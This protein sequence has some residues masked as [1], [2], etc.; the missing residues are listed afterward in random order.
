MSDPTAPPPG[1]EQYPPSGGYPPQQ[2]PPSQPP[3]GG[4][5]YPPQPPGG[6]Q[7]PP[8][9][10]GG[11]PPPQPGG[12]PPQ[13]PPAYQQ[14]YGQPGYGPP[15]T[16]PSPYVTLMNGQ[17]VK[18]ADF[19]QRAIGRVID[20]VIVWVVLVIINLILGAIVFG[21]AELVFNEETQ[22]FETSGGANFLVAWFLL[23]L[24]IALVVTILYEVMF[25]ATRGQTPGK[26]IIGTKVVDQA[27]GELIGWGP[28]FMRWLLP[29]VGYLFCYLGAILVYLSP[30]FDKSGRFQGWH[31]KMG[32]DLVISLK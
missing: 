31:D 26:M 11:Y 9:P 14:P 16:G 7:Y 28:S 3:P 10:P 22:Q 30:L 1:G 18:V 25:V 27:T 2:P 17:S 15:A 21:D 24:A 29:F 4:E 13:Q 5:Q 19:G 12:Y 32:K 23:P 6:E 20:V 8:Q